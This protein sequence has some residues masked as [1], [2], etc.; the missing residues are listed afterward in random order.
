MEDCLK[1]Y[2]EALAK[3]SLDKLRFLLGFLTLTFVE[4]TR[5]ENVIADILAAL[6]TNAENALRNLPE[7]ELRNLR[8]L[9]MQGEGGVLFIHDMREL[10]F[11]EMFHFVEVKAITRERFTVSFAPG[12]YETL[13]PFAGTAYAKSELDGDFLFDHF[14]FGSLSLYGAFTLTEFEDMICSS[15]SQEGEI[16]K[17]KILS[18]C[19]RYPI[20]ATLMDKDNL[21]YFP[22]ASDQISTIR[23]SIKESGFKQRKHFS[24]QQIIDAGKG[25]PAC[26]PAKNT[27]EGKGLFDTLVG[28]DFDNDMIPWIMTDFWE[29]MQIEGSEAVE[30]AILDYIYPEDGEEEDDPILLREQEDLLRKAVKEY[31]SV[32]PL[33]LYGGLSIKE[34]GK[35]FYSYHPMGKSSPSHEVRPFTK[36]GMNDPCPCGSGRLFKN[37]HGKNLN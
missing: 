18:R 23:K 11:S 17:K 16:L 31:L 34:A 28:M 1:Q 37:C 9:A 6:S 22:P 29:T 10:N 33:W 26:I 25:M 2:S 8:D 13:A 20:L 27:P 7:F 15:F 24:L 4:Q 14:L 19:Y 5:R 3:D 36:I 30:E 12:M 35:S 21:L 32:V